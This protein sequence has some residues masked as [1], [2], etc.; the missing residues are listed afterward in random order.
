MKKNILVIAPWLPYPLISG[1][2]QAIYNGLLALS[3]E[4]KVHCMY[5][6]RN[7]GRNVHEIEFK[8]NNPNIILV[9]IRDSST[10]RLSRDWFKACFLFILNSLGMCK[11]R[12]EKRF[13]IPSVCDGNVFAINEYIKK[14]DI[15]YVQIEMV[16]NI[17]II[18]KINTKAKKVF[19]HHELQYVVAQQVVER[20]GCVDTNVLQHLKKREI[21]LLN[22]Y[23]AVIVLSNEDRS[24]L[25]RENVVVPIYVSPAIVCSSPVA[26]IDYTQNNTLTFVGASSHEPNKNGLLWFLANCWTN[27]QHK[28]KLNVIGLWEEYHQNEILS[29]YK[30]VKFKGFVEDLPAEIRNTIMIVPIFEGSGIRMKIVEAAGLGVPFVTTSIGVGGLP[31]VDNENCFIADSANEFIEKMNTLNEK[32][33]LKRQMAERNLEIVKSQFCYENF[34]QERLKIVRDVCAIE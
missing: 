26:T 3:K 18:E 9:P 19:V 11:K 34:E 27:L 14:N 28:Y 5:F 30:N 10:K 31:F 20:K 4:F 17:G 12:Q 21:D 8:R 25:E 2:H 22:K 7:S 13:F 15:D 29:N 33:I 32:D 6:I 24:K 23:D 16:E 1:G